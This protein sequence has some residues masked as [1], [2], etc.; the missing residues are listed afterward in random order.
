MDV[1]KANDY[2]DTRLREI[3]TEMETILEKT[4]RQRDGITQHALS[5][6]LARPFSYTSAATQDERTGG[7]GR[8]MS[9]A[10]AASI[11]TGTPAVGP[12]E[13]A[14]VE[15]EVR[16]LCA[17]AVAR[18]IETNLDATLQPILEGKVKRQ[19][20]EL[21]QE[22]ADLKGTQQEVLT[23][24]DGLRTEMGEFKAHLKASV[25]QQQE[26]ARQ[27]AQRHQDDVEQRLAAWRGDVSVAVDAMH[28]L[29]SN[30]SLASQRVERRLAEAVGRHKESVHAALVDTEVQLAAWKNELKEFT[31]RDLGEMKEQ[32][33]ALEAQ[34]ARMQGVLGINSDMTSRH[35]ALL[36]ELLEDS[37]ERRS[38]VRLCRRDVNRLDMLVQCVGLDAGRGAVVPAA[39][40]AGSGTT[41]T[42]NNNAQQYMPTITMLTQELF[43]TKERLQ[44]L[45]VHVEGL[46]R[47]LYQPESAPVSG[48]ALRG[49]GGAV[50]SSK[51]PPHEALSKPAQQRQA[52][53][54]AQAQHRTVESAAPLGHSQPDG[55]MER[56]APRK[57]PPPPPRQR[58]DPTGPSSGSEANLVALASFP[59]GDHTSPTAAHGAQNRP[60][61][62]SASQ[63]NHTPM[64]KPGGASGARVVPSQRRVP[65]VLPAE[66]SESAASGSGRL[67]RTVD[68]TALPERRQGA[69]GYGELSERRSSYPYQNSSNP[70]SAREGAPASPKD[71]DESD[72][73]S[74]VSDADRWRTQPALEVGQGASAGPGAQ[75]PHQSSYEMHASPSDSYVSE[76]DQANADAETTS[77]GYSEA[78]RI[79]RFQVD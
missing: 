48:G 51:T 77:A 64:H 47:H 70:H 61:S 5:F 17:A 36:K 74:Y 78:E 65:H 7:A 23:R 73:D 28:E 68:H 11:L 31:C 66:D 52:P 3:N 71:A 46:E 76:N 45:A 55:G 25:A 32:R 54:E 24:M 35:S 49:G 14:L 79:G 19:L 8:G 56:T 15:Q 10:C 13:Q 16:K 33:G 22:V 20:Q 21:Q 40:D 60:G 38:E 72:V 75:V 43:K 63:F 44:V 42:N 18:W 29:R 67:Q 4:N 69:G 41:T 53:P 37:V 59:S 6:G 27:Q 39:A 34:L 2:F 30:Q 12:A 9:T 50:A 57:Q 62:R 1:A 26:Q 58:A